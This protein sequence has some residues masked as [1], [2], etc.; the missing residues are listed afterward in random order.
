M[1]LSYLTPVVPV[2]TF[3]TTKSVLLTGNSNSYL[4]IGNNLHFEYTA[5]R[6]FNFWI[7]LTNINT[8]YNSL[9]QDQGTA[10]VFNGNG[11]VIYVLNSNRGNVVFQLDNLLTQTE[12]SASSNT[13]VTINT[14]QNWVISYDG[15]NTTSGIKMWL[16]GSPVTMTAGSTG[17]SG[18][19]LSTTNTTIGGNSV[20][21]SFTFTGNA[22]DYSVFNMTGGDTDATAFYNGGVVPNLATLSQYSNILAWYRMGNL[23]GDSS[24]TIQNAANPGTYNAT[25]SNVSIVAYP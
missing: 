19:T 15:S 3:A 7:Y 25:G 4:N 16:N 22:I 20:S 6:T 21:S 14:V 8:H 2:N 24:S 18:T 5:T 11:V 10:G 17:V 9:W 13:P 1:G 23:A 12:L